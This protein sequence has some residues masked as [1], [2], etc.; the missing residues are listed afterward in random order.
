[1]SDLRESLQN[2]QGHE[3]SR[4]A[5]KQEGGEDTQLIKLRFVLDYQI[6]ILGA[7]NETLDFGFLNS[8]SI[9]QLMTLSGLLLS[10]ETS[11]P[12]TG[13]SQGLSQFIQRVQE[14]DELVPS[15][16]SLLYL[17]AQTLKIVGKMRENVQMFAL[18]KLF[19]NYQSSLKDIKR[20]MEGVF[21]IFSLSSR[22]FNKGG[23]NISLL[24]LYENRS[25]LE[26]SL[27]LNVKDDPS[28]GMESQLRVKKIEK[29]VGELSRNH[30]PLDQVLV[31]VIF[32]ISKKELEAHTAVDDKILKNITDVEYV[33][34]QINILKLDQQI[35][36]CVLEV[37]TSFFNQRYNLLTKLLNV[38]LVYGFEEKKVYKLLTDIQQEESSL[39]IDVLSTCISVLLAMDA[40]FKSLETQPTLVEDCKRRIDKLCEFLDRLTSDIMQKYEKK[41]DFKKTQNLLKNKG[42]HIQFMRLFTLQFQPEHHLTIFKKLVSFIYFFTS[43]NNVNK[44]L[45]F[46]HI[47]I[48]IDLIGYGVDSADLVS[49]ISQAIPDQ[50]TLARVVDYVFNKINQITST[51]EVQSM[52]SPG[53]MVRDSS[54][55]ELTTSLLK[56]LD[57]LISYK[58][59]LGGM[60]F[61]EK[62]FKREEI[63]RKIIF[64]LINNKDLVRIYELKFYNEIKALVSKQ[65]NKDKK[66]KK[67]YNFYAAYLSLLA[68]LSWEFRMGIDQA[69]RLVTKEQILEILTSA[70]T[71]FFFKKHFLKCF[72]HVFTFYPRYF[73]PR[74]GNK[75]L[76]KRTEN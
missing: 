44:K 12:Y 24:R 1:M 3:L 47:N 65:K 35:R 54:K 18:I 26:F 70:S 71:P 13:L 69:K 57:H 14:V 19:S 4:D 46:P 66:D 52:L 25:P 60:V 58:R 10:T 34:G 45:L 33:G 32:N 72:H 2:T 8:A 20:T 39:S 48:F 37:T 68:E 29:E 23:D 61:D 41:L 67:F 62:N 36:V 22:A 17:S 55:F 5:P 31:N 73:Y 75:S 76:G 56:Q 30:F 64:C 42:Y 9:C 50:K 21:N 53:A 27:E 40:R 59:V 28:D 15:F 74:K 38:E 43:Y 51:K 6:L 7:L 11:E 49:S 63:Q 16:K